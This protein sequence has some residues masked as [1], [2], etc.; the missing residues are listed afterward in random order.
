MTELTQISKTP[1]STED[2]P[3]GENGLKAI[4]EFRLTHPDLDITE[5][6]PEGARL[7]AEFC[8]VTIPLIPSSLDPSVGA[9]CL[10]C[11]DGYWIYPRGSIGK[12]VPCPECSRYDKTSEALKYSGIPNARKECRFASFDFTVKGT[13]ESFNAAYAMG[14]GNATYSILVMY[15]KRGCGKTHLAYAAGLE[16]I[17]RGRRVVFQYVAD[18]FSDMRSQ[19]S[20]RGD[21]DAIVKRL[22]ECEFLILDDLGVEPGTDFQASTIEG[23]VDYR[24]RHEIP[25]I[26]TTNKPPDSFDPAIVSRFNDATIC[27]LVRNS[28]V[29]YRGRK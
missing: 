22:K 2:S 24:Y 11:R 27:K 4:A 5:R 1:K 26:I 3:W 29:D 19:M 28:A 10:M 7:W 16:A 9:S 6:N 21:A 15:G 23:I 13:E 14:S 8:G 25:T 18:L 12:A 20:Q 17:Q